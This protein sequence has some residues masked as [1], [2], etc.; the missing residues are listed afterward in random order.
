MVIP[1][2]RFASRQAALACAQAVLLAVGASGLLL[3]E[4]AA[5]AQSSA[6]EML[7]KARARARD[8]EELKAVLNGPDQNM[9]LAAFDVMVNSGDDA[10]QQIAIDIGLASADSLLQAM[11]FKKVIMG[12]DRIVLTLEPVED[13]PEEGRT[14]AQNHLAAAGNSY[15]IEMPKK[16]EKAGT[17]SVNSSSNGEVSGTILTFKYQYDSGMLELQDD[18]TV[19]G[20]VTLYKSGYGKFDATARIR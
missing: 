17:F 11:A 5:Y 16:D 15:V 3:P 20:Q 14:A 7:E 8:M 12:L 19:N 13:Q 10:M 18:A 4:Q 2:F 1:R 9:R 6:A